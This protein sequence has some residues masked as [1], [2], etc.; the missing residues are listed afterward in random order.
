MTQQIVKVIPSPK[1][2]KRFRAIFNSG[3]HIDFGLKNGSTYIDNHDETKRYNYWRRHTSNEKE[4]HLIEDYIISPALL[5][6]YLL[7]GRYTILEK[8]IKY[9]NRLIV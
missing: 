3:I 6:A 4:A 7:W 8:N 5:S 9:L 1:R 2:N